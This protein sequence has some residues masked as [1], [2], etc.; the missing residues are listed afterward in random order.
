MEN[1]CGN[2][3]TYEC[4]SAEKSEIRSLTFHF[5]LLSFEF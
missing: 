5:L 4:I 3:C 2:K 1:V